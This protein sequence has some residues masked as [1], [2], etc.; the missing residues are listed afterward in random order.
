MESRGDRMTRWCSAAAP[1]LVT[2]L[3]A[4]AALGQGGEVV[5][6]P[7]A[8]AAQEAE[9]EIDVAGAP[10]ASSGFSPEGRRRM[11]EASKLSTTTGTLRNL[12]L[13]GLG[14]YYADDDFVGTIWM[15]LLAFGA[16]SLGWALITDSTDFYFYA[17]GFAVVAYTG[18]IVT[19]IFAVDSYN[20]TLRRNLKVS[21]TEAS[22]SPGRPE[23]SGLGVRVR[24]SF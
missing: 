2:L 12:A 17:A 8:A 13:P 18:S 7:V 22:L 21:P 16:T 24:L 9:E 19:T 5:E 15:G 6:A 4:S 10:S 3:W 11:Y 23:I 20:D 1:A 14:N